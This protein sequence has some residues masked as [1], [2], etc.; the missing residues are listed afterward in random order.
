MPGVVVAI[1]MAMVQV[2]IRASSPHDALLGCI[3]GTNT[4]RNTATNPDAVT[5]PGLIIYRFD[6]SLVFFNADHFK[7]RV[8]TVI[9]ETSEPVR[10]FLLDAETIPF[11]D[12]TGAASLDQVR[13]DLEADGIVMAVAEAKSTVRTMLDRTGLRERIG[14]DRMFPTVASAVEALSGDRKLI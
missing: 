6:A 4:Y 1:G 10:Y 2:L 9:S 8:E 14:A 11:L 7:T 13:G 3:P 12:T 5:V